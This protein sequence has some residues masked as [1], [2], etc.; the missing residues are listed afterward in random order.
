[1]NNRIFK[2]NKDKKQKIATFCS[3]FVVLFILIFFPEIVMNISDVQRTDIP[4]HIYV[5]IVLFLAVYYINYYIIIDR[6]FDG[7][8]PKIK[9][10]ACN[11]LLL[12]V[13]LAVCYIMWES[14]PFHHHPVMHNG[15]GPVGMPPLPPPDRYPHLPME[16]TD[17]QQV[18]HSL[19]RYIRDAV[20]M[21]FVVFLALALKLR[22]RW[23]AFVHYKNRVDAMQ[24]EAELGNLKAQL[25]PHFLF[26][27]LNSIYALIAVNPEKAQWAVHE[28]SGML[29]YMLYENPLTVKLKQEVDFVNSYVAL[30]CMRFCKN[31]ISVSVNIDESMDDAE[32]AP[33]LF[34]T[35]IENV[36]KHGVS[37]YK[38]KPAE[39]LLSADSGIV[40]CYTSNYCKTGET[41]SATGGIG[42]KNL[43]RRLNLIYG[44]NAELKTGVAGD[45][46]VV[47][48]VINLN[49]GANNK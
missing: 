19:N 29:R 13:M 30:M 42:L 43:R 16:M 18:A 39:I 28:L 31:N 9:F 2:E 22:S 41:E 15:H 34:V 49:N 11:I 14:E 47:E 5:K 32:I 45:T 3:H 20:M 27:T 7:R 26:N 33:L 36:F 40:R 38:D 8:N 12:G 44:K 17:L 4:T 37:Q 6:C 21:V 25:N 1:M 10:A 35:I 23:S 48:L 46:F 24:K